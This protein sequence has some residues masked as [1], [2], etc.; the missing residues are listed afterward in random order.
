M[1][2]LSN[3][4]SKKNKLVQRTQNPEIEGRSRVPLPSR[5]GSSDLIAFA[6]EAN[7]K[8]GLSVVKFEVT[9]LYYTPLSYAWGISEILIDILRRDSEPGHSPK[10]IEN[11]LWKVLLQNHYHVT[12]VHI[13]N[14]NSNE[15][16]VVERDYDLTAVSEAVRDVF[17][18]IWKVNK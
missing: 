16:E 11:D 17:T 5:L 2:K 7:K 8:S 10:N 12:A 13:I 9:G 4:K 1:P 14:E 18:T 6:M 3:K 15:V